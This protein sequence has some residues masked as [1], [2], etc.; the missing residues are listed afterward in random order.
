ME[1]PGDS[2]VVRQVMLRYCGGCN[3]NTTKGDIS[4]NF[5]MIISGSVQVIKD[6]VSIA[7]LNA[8]CNVLS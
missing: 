3:Y 6:D 1:L 4:E 2:V 7:E 8:G 5:Y